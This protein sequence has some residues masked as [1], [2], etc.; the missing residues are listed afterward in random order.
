MG[1]DRENTLVSMSCCSFLRKGGLL[2]TG[3]LSPFSVEVCSIRPSVERCFYGRKI[4][5]LFSPSPI[6]TGDRGS[7]PSSVAYVKAWERFCH[8]PLHEDCHLQNVIL[9]NVRKVPQSLFPKVPKEVKTEHS[10]DEQAL[11]GEKPQWVRTRDASKLRQGILV[12]QDPD[13]LKEFHTGNSNFLIWAQKKV[14]VLITQSCPILCDPTDC[15]CL[16]T[17]SSSGKNAAVGWHALLQGIFLTQG[18]NPGLLHCRQILYC[19]SHK[20]SPHGQKNFWWLRITAYSSSVLHPWL[21]LS[22]G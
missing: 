5:S 9:H 4:Q 18:L 7:N 13:L 14:K 1:R 16:Y 19:L 15:S 12:A 2:S 17:Q 11:R 22:L 6:L 21:W 20:R 3:S 10:Q 8:Q